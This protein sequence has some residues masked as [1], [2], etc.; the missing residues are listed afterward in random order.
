MVNQVRESRDERNHS[1]LLENII[2][3]YQFVYEEDDPFT[4]FTPSSIT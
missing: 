2:N 3:K 1:Y 4:V